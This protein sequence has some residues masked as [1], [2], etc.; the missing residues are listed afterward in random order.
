WARQW[1]EELPVVLWSIRTTPTRASGEAPFFLV[2]GVEVVLPS[3]LA[4][5]SPRASQYAEFDQ[6][7]RRADNINFIE[8]LRCRAALRAACYQQSLHRYHERKVKGWSLAVGDLV[9]HC[10]QTSLGLNKLS[11]CWEGPYT[12]VAVP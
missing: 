8:E 4:L 6:E 10:I 9:L 2:Y 7:S 12:V 3:E 1:I 11:L 5:G